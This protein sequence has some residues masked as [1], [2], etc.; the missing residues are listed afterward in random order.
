MDKNNTILLQDYMKAT[1]GTKMILLGQQHKFHVYINSKNHTRTRS[2]SSLGHCKV[3]H[4]KW[5]PFLYIPRESIQYVV[6]ILCWTSSKMFVIFLLVFHHRLSIKHVLPQFLPQIECESNLLIATSV[7]SFISPPLSSLLIYLPICNE[8]R[9][10]LAP[11][12]NNIL[13]TILAD[14]GYAQHSRD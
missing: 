5:V 8:M 2:I 7:Q 13:D 4:C 1:S 14:C 10:I 3:Y 12:V 11:M 6:D 9:S